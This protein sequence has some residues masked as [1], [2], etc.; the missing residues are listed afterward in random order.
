MRSRLRSVSVA[1]F[2]GV[3]W[4][5]AHA[6]AEESAPGD[7]GASA[8]FKA[9]PQPEEERLSDQA[10]LARVVSLVESARYEE[11][12]ARLSRLLDPKAP[13]AL[14]QPEII[15]TARLYHATCLIGLGKTEAA[16]QPLRDAVR[17]NPQMRAPDSL[18]FPAKVVDRFIKVRDELY[19]ELRRAQDKTIETARSAAAAKQK[20]ENE[21]W[22]RM[23]TLERLAQQEIVVDKNSRFIGLLP[24]G[25]GQ[26]Q[27]G[28]KALGWV[29]FGAEVAL[30]GTAVT[31]TAVY[32]HIA[33]QSAQYANQGRPPGD[34]VKKRLDDWYTAL[35]WSSYGFLGVAALGIIEAQISFVPEVRHVRDRPLPKA[36]TDQA[37]LH[38]APDFAVGPSDVRLGVRGSF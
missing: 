25:V 1:A 2:A 29:F 7:D 27:N 9:D 26:F 37:K 35:V 23:L 19:D 33:S 8:A 17:K 6:R 31:S 18:I 16:D 10:E 24:F 36:L 15:E 28:N 38:L 21:R 3:L 4:L 20:Q 11:C 5:S 32:T 12:A 30:A 22:A 34:D 13:H 14:K